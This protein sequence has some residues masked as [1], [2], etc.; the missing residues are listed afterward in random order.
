[1]VTIKRGS[2]ERQ[3]HCLRVN[4]VYGRVTASKKGTFKAFDAWEKE[5][6]H[7][8]ISKYSQV[9]PNKIY[10]ITINIKI[11]GTYETGKSLILYAD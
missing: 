7:L 4:N 1:M 8:N 6:L 2:T 11:L 10:K 3:A 9:D 5:I